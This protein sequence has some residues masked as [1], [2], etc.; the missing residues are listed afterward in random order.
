LLYNPKHIFV[1]ASQNT[2]PELGKG[3]VLSCRGSADG[4][5]TA[6]AVLLPSFLIQ[7]Q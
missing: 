4:T 5:P 3:Q 6:G 2:A 1:E 7:E